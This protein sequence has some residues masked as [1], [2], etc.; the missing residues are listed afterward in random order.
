M[1]L[2]FVCWFQESPCALKE[3]YILP[4]SGYL[5]VVKSRIEEGLGC[6]EGVKEWKQ[7]QWRL[8]I[9]LGDCTLA[10]MGNP[11]LHFLLPTIN[12][13]AEPGMSSPGWGKSEKCQASWDEYQGLL[14]S[15]ARA[16]QMGGGKNIYLYIYIYINNQVG[17]QFYYKKWGNN[18][19][20]YM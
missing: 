14:A 2:I 7:R 3:G 16:K 19:Y 9:Y 10:M 5:V 11:F 18:I 8:V 6:L 4:D 20:I 12:F 15:S 13:L 17:E 1:S